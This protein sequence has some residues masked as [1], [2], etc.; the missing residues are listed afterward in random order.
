MS[1]TAAA[2][3]LLAGQ[4]VLSLTVELPRTES[5]DVAYEELVAGQDQAALA[6]LLAAREQ[7][8]QDPAVLINLGAAYARLGRLAESRAAYDAAIL[9]DQR[10]DL[11]TGSGK[12]MDSRYIARAAKRGGMDAAATL[13]ML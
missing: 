3:A 5:R 8:R 1:M 13:A 2:L 7:D 9:S 11:E 4:S 10:Y 6:K 12:W